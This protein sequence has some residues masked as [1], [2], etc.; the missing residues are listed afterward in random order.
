MGAT[1]V[2]RNNGN[3]RNSLRAFGLIIDVLV[4]ATLDKKMALITKS[5]RY[6]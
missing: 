2:A 4:N 6:A 5:E 3:N 1:G